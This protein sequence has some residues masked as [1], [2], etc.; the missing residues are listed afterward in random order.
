LWLHCRQVCLE[1][2]SIFWVFFVCRKSRG[3][4]E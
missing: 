4:G 3:G 1:S 2:S